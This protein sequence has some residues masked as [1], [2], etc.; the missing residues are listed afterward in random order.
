MLLNNIEE[1][2]KMK[3]VILTLKGY[4]G[5]NAPDLTQIKTIFEPWFQK[6]KWQIVDHMFISGKVTLLRLTGEDD[7]PQ[8]ESCISDFY[9]F[10][11]DKY[12]NL[13]VR[14]NQELDYPSLR[15]DRGIEAVY[16][17]TS[18]EQD[19]NIF[20]A[21]ALRNIL[22]SIPS[23]VERAKNSVDSLLRKFNR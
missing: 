15:L 20:A 4:E 1:D 11:K 2:L 12:G 19:S 23:E 13:G 3:T 17:A 10:V 8:I 6:M 7:A 16:S 9:K 14:E 21:M 18:N 22:E 5:N